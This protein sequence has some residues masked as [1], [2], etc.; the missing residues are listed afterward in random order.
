M[1][2]SEG[3][4]VLRKMIEDDLPLKVKWA[5]D[6]EVNKYVGFDHKINL[7]ETRKWFR[8]QDNN[9]KIIL[10]T[11]LLN[12]EPIGYMKLVKDDI[13]NVGE[14]LGITIGEKQYWGKGYGK[15]AVKEFLKYCFHKEK[16]N[17]LFGQWSDWNKRSINLHKK[18]GFKVEGTFKK[19]TKQ[20]DE[21]S[22]NVY[23]F[24][25][26]KEEWDNNSD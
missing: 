10:L 11:I 18:L 7:E 16:L 9:N 26:T 8:K 1:K 14:Y 21:K 4:I 24:S 3:I 6:R 19:Y 15:K 22:Y 20:N 12:K 23:I 5:N 17:K 25:M 2:T 13:N